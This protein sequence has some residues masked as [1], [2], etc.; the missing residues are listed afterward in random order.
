MPNGISV[1]GTQ[2]KFG[3]FFSGDIGSQGQNVTKTWTHELLH[4]LGLPDLAGRAVGWE[5]L[6][7]GSEPPSLTH[8]LGWHKW[9]LG[10]DRPARS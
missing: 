8:L 2:V 4:T 7:V 10:V 6:A 1:D 3:N 9:L 5:P